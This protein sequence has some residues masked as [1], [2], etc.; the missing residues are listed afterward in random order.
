MKYFLL[1]LLFFS[2]NLHACNECIWNIEDEL[3][4]LNESYK[5]LLYTSQ[6]DEKI[7]QLDEKT[8]F[9]LLG[10][11][12]SLRSAQEIIKKNKCSQKISG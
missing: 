11:E 2:I 5:D 1:F 10:K 7:H 9:Y 3:F 8:Y 6:L 12:E 4:H